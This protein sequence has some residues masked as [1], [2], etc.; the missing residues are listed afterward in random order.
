MKPAAPNSS[1][2]TKRK[3]NSKDA[4]PPMNAGGGILKFMRRE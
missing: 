3:G 4:P 1:L 2:G